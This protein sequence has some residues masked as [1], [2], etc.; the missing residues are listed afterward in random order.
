[1]RQASIQ[2]RL[3]LFLFSN[4]CIWNM[5]DWKNP[6]NR[7][8][9]SPDQRAALPYVIK[10]CS[11]TWTDYD[12]FT[13][14]QFGQIYLRTNPDSSS[15]ENFGQ[16]YPRTYF[17]GFTPSTVLRQTVQGYNCNKTDKNSSTTDYSRSS[18]QSL[19]LIPTVYV[20]K[21]TC[22]MGRFLLNVFTFFNCVKKHSTFQLT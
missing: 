19:E 14:K 16:F 10:N 17:D 13:L 11:N 2:L 5:P 20:Y 1:M 3:H 4:F 22:I 12:R 6:V 9:L 7:P 21:Y 18:E 15:Y 8:Q